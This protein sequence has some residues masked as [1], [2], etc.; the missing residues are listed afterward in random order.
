MISPSGL[1]PAAPCPVETWD[2]PHKTSQ[3]HT[4]EKVVVRRRPRF[5]RPCSCLPERRV[6]AAPYVNVGGRCACFWAR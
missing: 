6:L 4:P 5:Q 1:A 2:Y 3:S